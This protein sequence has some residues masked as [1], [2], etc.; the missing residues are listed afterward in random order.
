MGNAQRTQVQLQPN[1]TIPQKSNFQKPVLGN[2]GDKFI[3]A[4]GTNDLSAVTKYLGSPSFKKFGINYAVC[5]HIKILY[6][7]YIN[8]PN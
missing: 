8:L 6:N 2:E 4:C 7:N 1:Y 5:T 3:F